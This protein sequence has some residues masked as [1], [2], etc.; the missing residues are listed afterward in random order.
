MNELPYNDID[1]RILEYLEG[2]L[3]PNQEAALLEEIRQDPVLQNRL[4][5]FRQLYKVMASSQEPSVPSGLADGFNQMLENEMRESPGLSTGRS[6]IAWR[7]AA[8]LLLLAALSVGTLW[9]RQH[10]VHEQ[11][12]AQ[13]R[14]E[15]EK[16]RA[17]ILSMIGD[18]Q[19]PSQRMQG[20]Q[21][22]MKQDP[23]DLELKQVLLHTL[24]ED[25][26]SNVRLAAL[27]ALGKLHQ[28]QGIAEELVKSL[29]LQ[30]DPVVQIALIRL[31]VQWKEKEV[32]PALEEI[33]RSQETIRP[34]KD[35]AYSG[36]LKLS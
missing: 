18:Q 33:I 5:Q 28:N 25:P 23:S 26:N 7:T 10:Q 14:S 36:L 8:V 13:I 9:F 32:K 22:A 27:E 4:E 19:S 31:L 3:P 24:N 21:V 6:I 16:T 35:E 12:L 17:I 20:V 29:P 15:M 1:T 2:Q 34:V 11:E 30:K